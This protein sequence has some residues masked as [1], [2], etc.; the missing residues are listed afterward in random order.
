MTLGI[1]SQ[2]KESLTVCNQ[3]WVSSYYDNQ[4]I[5]K[6]RKAYSSA[7][8]KSYNFGSTA[9]ARRE[10]ES[11]MDVVYKDANQFHAIESVCGKLGVYE[12]KQRVLKILDEIQSILQGN[13]ILK[14]DVTKK[15][16][17]EVSKAIQNA[18]IVH[19]TTELVSEMTSV[20]YEM[21]LE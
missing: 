13:L 6:A 1:R 12:S 15:E 17:L 8:D 10:A 7:M 9:K 11:R 5:E 2:G 16:M 20:V 3:L 18:T 19:P 14:M 4:T 21:P